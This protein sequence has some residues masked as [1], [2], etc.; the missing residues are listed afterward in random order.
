MLEIRRASPFD[1]EVKVL[2]GELDRYQRSIY[3]EE[4]NHLDPVHELA[5]SNVC[6]LGAY[7]GDE[8]VGIGAVKYLHADCD[9]GE[10]KRVYVKKSTR[11]KGISQ[12]LMKQLEVDAQR[13]G[14]AVLRLETGVHQPEAV[15][16]YEKLGYSRC[17]RFGAYPDDPVSV[18]MEKKLEGG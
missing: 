18:F 9:Y 2:I 10:I 11:R 16:L 15:G 3:P 7:L 12:S 8:L 13:R 5:K 14:V 4:S 6:F 1:P 17:G